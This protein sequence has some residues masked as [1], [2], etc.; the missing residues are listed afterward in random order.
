MP[1]TCPSPEN[2]DPHPGRGHCL[3]GPR[4]RD[5][6]AGGPGALVC[7]MHSTAHCSPLALCN[8]LCEVRGPSWWWCIGRR[9]MC[10]SANVLRWIAHGPL[11]RGHDQVLRK[12]HSAQELNIQEDGRVRVQLRN[13]KLLGSEFKAERGSQP[14]RASATA[15]RTVP[16]LPCRVLVMDEGQV[17]ESGSPAQLLAQKGLFYRLAQESGLA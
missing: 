2:P 9:V 8:G 5:A 14:M 12:R 15:T 4:D 3:R 11:L 16:C 10:S 1:G 17:A 13:S 7:S 6:D